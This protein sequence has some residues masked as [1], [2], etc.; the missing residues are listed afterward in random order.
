MGGET[1]RAETQAVF[2]KCEESIKVIIAWYEMCATEK[3][4]YGHVRRD[5][6]QRDEESCKHGKVKAKLF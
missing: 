1:A 5:A 3:G 2:W 6:D 4:L